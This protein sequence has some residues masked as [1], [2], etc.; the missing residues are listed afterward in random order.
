MIA[1]NKY[2]NKSRENLTQLQLISEPTLAFNMSL[3]HRTTSSTS[4]QFNEPAHSTAPRGVPAF[5]SSPLALIVNPRFWLRVLRGFINILPTLGLVFVLTKYLFGGPASTALDA[6]G[7]NLAAR[8]PAAEE[9]L[10]N[11][12]RMML[13]FPICEKDVNKVSPARR[14]G[15]VAGSL[16]KRSER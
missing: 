10:L 9:A 16:S 6:H 15:L 5:A 2:G 1:G 12:D 4:A 14:E 13:L 7:D 11:G 3:R 8:F